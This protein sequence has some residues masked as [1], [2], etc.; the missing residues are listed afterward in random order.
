MRTKAC[1][2]FTL[3]E[4]ML[5][6]LF[7]SFIAT[8]TAS[9]MVRLWTAS[10]ARNKKQAMLITLYT[11]HDMLVR[12]IHDASTDRSKWK[13]IGTECIIWH[14]KEGD[15]GWQREQ[16][17]LVRRDGRYSAKKKQWGKQT[18]NLIAD[19][20][21]EVRFVC[22]GDPEISHISFAI[23]AGSTRVEGVAAPLCRRLPWKEE[24]K[25]GEAS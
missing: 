8:A 20:I 3:L 19:H 11:A 22:T 15:V 16:E 7:V 10:T 5:Y 25:K 21:D 2:G 9:W 6:V 12:D 24:A 18:K 14:T 17:Q 4:M 1:N 13:E 23:T